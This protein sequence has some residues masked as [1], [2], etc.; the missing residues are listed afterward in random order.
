MRIKPIRNDADLQDA[1]KRLKVIFQAAEGTPDFDEMEVLVTLI[2][3]YENQHAPIN[4]ASPS[5][6]IQF[7]MDL[8]S[9]NSPPKQ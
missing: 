6:A 5:D 2:E 8:Q 3:S 1:F 4:A 7:R 9:P